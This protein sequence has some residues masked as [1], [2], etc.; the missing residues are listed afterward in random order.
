MAARDDAGFRAEV[1]R[2]RT[3]RARAQAAMRTAFERSP[4]V[5][6]TE[7]KSYRELW[8]VSPETVR[9]DGNVRVTYLRP[10][11]PRGH[12]SGRD[13]EDLVKEL[14]STRSTY[15]PV[16]EAFVMEW[17]QTPEYQEGQLRVAFVQADNQLR[18]LAGQRG[19][20]GRKWASTI[21]DQVY[22]MDDVE[23]ATKVLERAA[24]DLQAGRAPNTK[25]LRA[26]LLNAF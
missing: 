6:V 13:M 17:T 19:E 5:L 25:A 22:Q 21:Q 2:M 18:W 9:T 20:Q 10:D 1:S 23:Q 26:R 15:D 24:A 7:G 11:G 8:I 4:A 12:F 3:D 16:D 14:S